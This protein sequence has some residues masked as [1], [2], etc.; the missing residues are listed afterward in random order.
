MT[1][2]RPASPV[3]ARPTPAMLSIMLPPLTIPVV[4]IKNLRPRKFPSV[5]R[6]HHAQDTEIIPIFCL[7]THR[8]AA[9]SVY[10]QPP[11]KNTTVVLPCSF[12]SPV[13][14]LLAQHHHIHAPPQ[15]QTQV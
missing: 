5:H 2:H 9:I 4:A 7:P 14:T 8:S 6:S 10:V 11:R 13:H 12:G 3:V 15:A 1:S